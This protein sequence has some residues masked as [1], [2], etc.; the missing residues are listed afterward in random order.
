VAGELAALADEYLQA[1]AADVR[2]VGDQVLRELLGV[3]AVRARPDGVLSLPDGMLLAV[4]GQS[5]EVMP[6]PS[7]AVQATMRK[8]ADELARRRSEALSSAGQPAVTGDGVR[9]QVRAR[10]LLDEAIRAD[11][12]GSPS[13]LQ[14][15][16][17]VEIPST[18]LKTATFTGLVDFFSIGTNDLTQY[19][20]AAERGNEAVAALGDPWIPG[21]SC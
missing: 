11:G 12:R 19:A 16:I 10:E 20:L 14:V 4:D 17:M 18:A 21:Y 3:A 1:R 7:P 8:R 15:G 9:I 13:G 5:G 2:A 6:D